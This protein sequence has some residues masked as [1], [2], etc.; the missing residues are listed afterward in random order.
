M[1]KARPAETDLEFIMGVATGF[2]RARVLFSAVEFGLFT[3]LA[4]GPRSGAELSEE[5]G[6]DPRASQDF[7]DALVALGLVRRSDG[8]YENSEAADRLLNKKQDTYL[9]GFLTF[10]GRALY[11][12]WGQLS[13]LLRTGE[14]QEG[15]DSFGEFYR[16]R[17]RVRGFMAAMDSASAVVTDQLIQRFDWGRYSSVLDLGGAR[18]NLVATIVKAHPHLTGA[19]FDLPPV[20]PLFDEHMENL[21]MS[22]KVTFHGGDF[23]KDPLPSADVMVFGHVLHDW[24]EDS[25][26]LLV[27]RAFEALN[28]GGTLLIYD[29][30]I[31]DDRSGPTHSLL[32]SLNMKL[33]R[34]GAAEYTAAEAHAWLTAAGFAEVRVEELTATERL[35]VAQK[36]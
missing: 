28:P 3:K 1:E 19:C 22:D 35:L 6:L 20:R 15:F 13:E 27:R 10:M 24:D 11:P 21:G 31:D 36:K 2:W 29:E 33:V 9:G 30:I 32:M 23:R 34:S 26:R 16:D 4:T 8:R 14:I 25:R 17:D 18:G 7:L 12:A 5:L